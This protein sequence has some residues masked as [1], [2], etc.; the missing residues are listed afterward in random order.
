MTADLDDTL[1]KL[2]ELQKY[3]VSQLNGMENEEDK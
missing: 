2:S 1:G 3:L